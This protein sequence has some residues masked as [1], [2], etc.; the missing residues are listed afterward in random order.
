MVN[1][2]SSDLQARVYDSKA[3]HDLAAVLY[4]SDAV[5]LPNR[6]RMQVPGVGGEENSHVDSNLGSDLRFGEERDYGMI[7]AI[8]DNRPFEY[9]KGSHTRAFVEELKRHSY[10]KYSEKKHFIQF[11]LEKRS[12]PDPL[13]LRQQWARCKLRSGDLIIWTTHMIHRVPPTIGKRAIWSMFIS[14]ERKKPDWDDIDGPYAVPGPN[15]TLSSPGKSKKGWRT[16]DN[17]RFV[18]PFQ[19]GPASVRDANLF[20]L[21]SNYQPMRWPSNKLCFYYMNQGIANIKF[22]PPY[23]RAIEESKYKTEPRLKER[24]VWPV[25]AGDSLRVPVD[26]IS[27]RKL[28]QLHIPAAAWRLKN[29]AIDP[30]KL[31][32]ETQK[33]LGFF[34][35]RLEP[36]YVL[37]GQFP[38]CGKRRKRYETSSGLQE[39]IRRKHEA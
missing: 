5:I 28:D 19:K 31:K 12:T 29:W 18:C 37:K 36:V 2:Y 6:L 21:L 34:P 30:T 24:P 25:G 38:K 35:P 11:H 9:V 23:M 33:L 8:N 20:T 7:L 27:S 26:S 4:K 1:V 16:Y 22:K 14:V 39:H 3:L 10:F 13:N 17:A 32:R 15:R